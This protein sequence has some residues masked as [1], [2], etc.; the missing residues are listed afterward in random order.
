MRPRE[1]PAEEVVKP[2]IVW[3][4]RKASMRPREL[5]AE[6][7]PAVPPLGVPSGLQ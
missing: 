7:A 6:E 2:Y 4:Q 3:E 1:L 5:P